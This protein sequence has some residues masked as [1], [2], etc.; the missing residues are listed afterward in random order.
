MIKVQTDFHNKM[1]IKLTC[2]LSIFIDNSTVIQTVAYIPMYNLCY[3]YKY[4]LTVNIH[5]YLH[6]AS[7]SRTQVE[8][9]L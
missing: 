6:S 8:H 3:V 9:N 5:C 1:E 2:F 4:R 7:L